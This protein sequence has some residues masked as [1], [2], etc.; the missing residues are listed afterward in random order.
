VKTHEI[1]INFDSE[2]ASRGRILLDGEDIS[3]IVTGVELNAYVGDVVGLTLHIIPS[4]LRVKLVGPRASV[5]EAAYE[6]VT[7][8]NEPAKRHEAD[9]P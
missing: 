7:A 8:L 5:V 2:S 4:R 1:E 3:Q 9:A 6:R